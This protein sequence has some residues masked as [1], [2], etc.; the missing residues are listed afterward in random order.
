MI[1]T[2][3]DA[4]ALASAGAVEGVDPSLASD[5]KS[6]RID[7]AAGGEEG[8]W[9]GVYQV[10]VENASTELR[11][12]FVREQK[13]RQLFTDITGVLPVLQAQGINPDLRKLLELWFEAAGVEDFEAIFGTAP[14]PQ[15]TPEQL[16]AIAQGGN[17]LQGFQAGQPALDNVGAPAAQPTADN[18]G[19][20]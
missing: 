14:P 7:P 10:F 18:S 1:V 3:R 19:L 17:A 5:V 11:D 15:R 9:D 8:M 6:V 20:L 4:Q 16:S 2:G 12:P 13:F